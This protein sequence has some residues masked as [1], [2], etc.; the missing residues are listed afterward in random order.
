MLAVLMKREADR[1]ETED[2]NT[3]NHG[4]KFEERRG[5]ADTAASVRAFGGGSSIEAE[6]WLEDLEI[7]REDGRWSWV[8]TKS[9]LC[10]KLVGAAKI[11]HH[12]YGRELDSFEKWLK[13]FKVEFVPGE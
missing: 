1:V 8:T 12:G 10:S 5:F 6:G 13:G 9:V 11:W 7:R 2:K 4:D 3:D